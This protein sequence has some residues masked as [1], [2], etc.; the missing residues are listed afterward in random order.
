MFFVF[1]I[2]IFSIIP[3]YEAL[4]SPREKSARASETQTQSIFHPFFFPAIAP[5]GEHA[6]TWD[7]LSSFQLTKYNKIRDFCD[8]IDHRYKTLGWKP[9]PCKQ[10]PWTYDLISEGGEP[11]IYW[12]YSDVVAK[13]RQ[14]PADSTTTLLLGGV[15][16]DE[17]TPIHLAFRFAEALYQEP[18]TYE[19]SI[20]VVVPIVNPDGFLSKKLSRTNKNGVDL[21]RNFA[22]QDWWKNARAFWHKRRKADSRYFPGVAPETEQGTRF[23]VDLLQRFEPDKVL[24]VHAPL[25]LLDYDGPGDE[26]KT[27]LTEQE[28]K[29]KEVASIIAKSAS[30]YKVIDYR[31]YPGSLGNYLGNERNIPTITVE[32]KSTD[33]K[34]SEQYWNEFKW[35]LK[36]AVQYEFKKFVGKTSINEHPAMGLFHSIEGMQ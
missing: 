9:S 3:F 10:L 4:G 5:K 31:F 34:M 1:W 20:V 24:S 32:L 15:H 25:G 13:Q 18:K 30:K 26:K 35:G 29:A 7:P 23:Q 33:P 21:N 14:R 6:P 17:R 2:C 8:K 11:L 12:V 36:N 22:T 27:A 28:K 16:P 19:G